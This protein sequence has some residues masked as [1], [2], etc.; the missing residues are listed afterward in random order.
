MTVV[1]VADCPLLEGVVGH[2]GHVAEFL[3]QSEVEER[4]EEKEVPN[5][6][7]WKGRGLHRLAALSFLVSLVKA[8]NQ[9]VFAGLL[10]HGLLGLV[11]VGI[12]TIYLCLS[13]FL[14]IFLFIII[15]S[16]MCLFYV[17]VFLTINLF[18][19]HSSS[20]LGQISLK[21][22]SIGSS[23]T[24]CLAKLLSSYCRYIPCP[25]VICN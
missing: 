4:E 10:Q 21:R 14:F 24:C 5:G 25:H 23:Y 3:R 7:Q 15:Y 11:V 19:I 16:F 13:L 8:N 1:K 9:R 20:I 2:L 12:S 6:E 18:R 17:I 22:R